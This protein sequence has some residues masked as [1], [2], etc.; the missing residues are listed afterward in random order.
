MLEMLDWNQRRRLTVAALIVT[1]LGWAGC[2]ELFRPKEPKCA[3]GRHPSGGMCC[4]KGEEWVEAQ[5]ACIC[6]DPKAC[7]PAAAASATSLP[8]AGALA[9]AGGGGGAAT[10]ARPGPHPCVGTWTGQGKDSS[11]ARVEIE[12]SLRPLE[13]GT[14]DRPHSATCG[15]ASERTSEVGRCRF[16][17]VRCSHNGDILITAAAGDETSE[18]GESSSLALQCA[19][20]EV[21]YRRSGEERTVRGVLQPAA[22]PAGEGGAGPGAKR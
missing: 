14:I 16:R 8:T 15:T 21:R 1:A 17:L 4:G 22:S 10:R 9:A 3:E 6:L 7:G 18:C 20:S 13:P 12:V 11:G 2:K 19:G 5:R